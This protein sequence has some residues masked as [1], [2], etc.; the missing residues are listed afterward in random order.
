MSGYEKALNMLKK[1]STGVYESVK[2]TEASV[3]GRKLPGGLEEERGFVTDTKIDVNKSGAPYFMLFIAVETPEPY[4]GVNNT[5]YYGLTATDYMS[6][7][8]AIG[9]LV[10]DMK[11]LG[12]DTTQFDDTGDL[13]RHVKETVK[14]KKKMPCLYNTGTRQ[15]NDGSYKIFIAGVPDGDAS[16]DR[17][18]TKSKRTQAKSKKASPFSVGDDVETT[19]DYFGDGNVYYGV[20]EAV[21][22]DTITVRFKDDN[23]VD[24]IPA[25]SLIKSGGES[26]EA[27]EPDEPSDI[28]ELGAAA[29]NGDEEA[30][31][32][33]AHMAQKFGI[34]PDEF[35]LWSEVIEQLPTDEPEEEATDESADPFEVGEAVITTGDYFGVGEEYEGT[36][37]AVNEDGTCTVEFEDETTDVPVANLEAAS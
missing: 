30:Q 1:R 3:G 21:D 18:E 11:L 6:E 16:E 12:F 19:G 10:N 36:V 9:N 17:A 5:I 23:A 27:D 15:G 4:K 2:D 25:A 20:A 31:A 37:T 32:A 14:K 7:E 13:L 34:D 24:D 33:I 8:E 26:D 22:G 29:D 28:T 35:E